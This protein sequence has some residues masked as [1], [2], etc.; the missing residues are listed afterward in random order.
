MDEYKRVFYELYG[1]RD[2]AWTS[3]VSSY[4][5]LMRMKGMLTRGKI[6]T[7]IEKTASQCMRNIEGFVD[8]ID[9]EGWH[10]FVAPMRHFIAEY[11]QKTNCTLISLNEMIAEELELETRSYT[12]MN[13]YWRYHYQLSSFDYDIGHFLKIKHWF[14][15][16]KPKDDEVYHTITNY[17]KP[18]EDHI[19]Y[20]LSFDVQG[21]CTV[22]LNTKNLDASL[23]SIQV[24]I[25]YD[26][27][28]SH[29]KSALSLLLMK[30]LMRTK[31]GLLLLKDRQETIM[32]MIG[33]VH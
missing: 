4:H 10:H 13:R 27:P 6:L 19:W 3:F 9:E 17:L 7:R 20:N 29:L 22:T 1:I 23:G 16:D 18:F 11:W 25:H 33:R 15:T 5:P 24:F 14:E 21:G 30:Q 28:L 31:E 2:D 8:E 32:G 12:F 26:S